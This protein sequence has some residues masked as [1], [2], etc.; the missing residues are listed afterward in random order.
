MNE[1]I[2][3]LKKAIEE[4]ELKK[5]EI[6]LEIGWDR[7]RLHALL[8]HG[9]RIDVEDYWKIR[10]AIED[11]GVKIDGLET[12]SITGLAA[13]IN[14]ESS[15]LIEECVK[16]LEDGYLTIGERKTLT[17]SIDSML[18]KLSYLKVRLKG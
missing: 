11:R 12:M 14:T 9:K 18:E 3:S 8:D 15:K 10:K 6:A 13:Y 1:A 16:S 7:Q 5:S 4:N 2:L 17:G